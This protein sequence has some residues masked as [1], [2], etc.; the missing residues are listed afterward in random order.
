[1][2]LEIW[3]DEGTD[4]ATLIRTSA[5]LEAL[6]ERA[7]GVDYPILLEVLDAASPNWVIL[8]VGLNGDLGVLRYAGGDHRRGLYSRNRETGTSQA[9][10][11]LYYYMN[12]DSEFPASAQCP[13]DVVLRACVEFMATG[14]DLP[15]GVEWQ[16]WPELAGRGATAEL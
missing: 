12:S 5:E 15:T 11:V 10:I 16:P 1:M 8:N 2:E 9:E 13:V 3:G 7:R 14:G 4:E 6:L